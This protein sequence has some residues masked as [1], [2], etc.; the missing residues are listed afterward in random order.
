M[1]GYGSENSC[2]DD[3]MTEVCRAGIARK[4]SKV[5]EPIP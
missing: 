1:E 5:S 3:S 4:N 2:A